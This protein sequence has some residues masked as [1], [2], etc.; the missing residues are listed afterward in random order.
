MGTPDTFTGWFESSDEDLNQWFYDAVY[1]TDMGTTI[2]EADSIDPRNADSPG[3]LDRLV[4][5]DG[6]KRDRLPYSGDLAVSARTS[7]L[8]AMSPKLLEMF[9]RTWRTIRDPMDGSTRKHVSQEPDTGGFYR[10][11]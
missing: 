1:T 2:L 5:L 8:L 9:S 10:G 6:P 7:Y 11:H 4:L 3:M